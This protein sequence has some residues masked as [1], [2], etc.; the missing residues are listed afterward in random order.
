[1]TSPTDRRKAT[2]GA[3]GPPSFADRSL[4]VAFLHLAPELGAL[5]RNRSLIE[6]GTRVAADAGANW[7]V[8]GELV[9]PGYRF[10]PLI[11]THWIGEQP[12]SWMLR[13]ARLSSELGVASFVSHPEHDAVTGKLFNS[14]F[15][16]GRNGQILGRHRKLRPTPGSED[17][18]SAGEPGRPI[19][20]DGITVGLL[21]CA[22]ACM[23]PPAL[24]L[25]GSGAQLLV[26]AAA[27]WPGEW[28]PKGEWEARTLDTGLPMIV[29]NRTGS[30]HETQLFGSESVVVD[31][32]EKVL[33]L[34]A[35]ESTVF[36]VDCQFSNGHIAK[37]EL[38][39]SVVLRPQ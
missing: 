32:G 10:E 24:R 12:D 20:V 35:P 34:R 13:L 18:S 4:T 25:R 22:D 1:M 9:V 23:A 16:I 7:V 6:Y 28:G 3:A 11:G 27:W 36:F 38:T 29:C 37:C 26:S 30:E 33:T 15:V 2:L 31:R 21:I 39:E 17:W 14:L 8:S 5:D 19:P